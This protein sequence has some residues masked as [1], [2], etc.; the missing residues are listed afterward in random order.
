MSRDIVVRFGRRLREVRN[1]KGIIQTVLAERVGTDQATISRIE[2][3]KQEP[4]LQFIDMLATGLKTP[5]GELF[6]D[7]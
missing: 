4:C 2:N 5:L 3:G 1:A 6:K 7:M